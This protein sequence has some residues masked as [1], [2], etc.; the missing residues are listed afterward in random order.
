MKRW[1]VGI[2][3][4][5]FVVLLGVIAYLGIIASKDENNGEINIEDDFDAT[6]IEGSDNDEK[7]DI[8]YSLEELEKMALDYYEMKTGYRPS[9]VAAEADAENENIVNI[10]LYDNLGD[11]NSTSDWYRVNKYTGVGTNMLEEEIDLKETIN[12]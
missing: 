8:A 1:V 12:K 10:Q 5:V 6:V 2:V 11:H 4:V 3:L 9:S 7:K